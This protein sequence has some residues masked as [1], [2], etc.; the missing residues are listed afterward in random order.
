MVTVKPP[1]KPFR[2]NCYGYGCFYYNSFCDR[3]S[4]N[5]ARPGF[6]GSYGSMNYAMSSR[7]NMFDYGGGSGMSLGFPGNSLIIGGSM[8]M[9][10]SSDLNK[11]INNEVESTSKTRPHVPEPPEPKI[12]KHFPETWIWDVIDSSR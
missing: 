10:V 12:R 1:Y 3:A 8:G 11:R 7:S 5:M 2:E 9:E 4:C 6:F